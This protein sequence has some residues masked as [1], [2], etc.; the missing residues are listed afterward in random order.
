MTVVARAHIGHWPFA[1]RFRSIHDSFVRLDFRGAVCVLADDDTLRAKSRSALRLKRRVQAV[2]KCRSERRS[3]HS[4]SWPYLA[5]NGHAR[6]AAIFSHKL[7]AFSRQA[8]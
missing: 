1:L 6:D 4:L 7:R 2:R 3:N 5:P 8:T